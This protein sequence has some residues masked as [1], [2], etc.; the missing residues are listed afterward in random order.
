M[1][2]TDETTGGPNIIQF[3]VNNGLISYL[4]LLFPLL[5]YLM[6]KTNLNWLKLKPSRHGFGVTT[7]KGRTF[8]PEEMIKQNKRN[9]KITIIL[10]VISAIVSAFAF[11]YG[12]IR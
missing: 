7:T 8:T 4:L 9:L 1:L 5:I 2:V 6:L 12:T 3:T 11:I 10:L